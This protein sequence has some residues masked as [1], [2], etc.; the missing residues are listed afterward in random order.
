MVIRWV[1]QTGNHCV[2]VL[3]PCIN[4]HGVVED[5]VSMFFTE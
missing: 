1:D 4:G 2:V 5:G 3:W